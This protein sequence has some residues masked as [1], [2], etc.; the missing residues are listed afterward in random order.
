MCKSWSLHPFPFSC[1]FFPV[2]AQTLDARA[3]VP[4]KTTKC[5]RFFKSF[6]TSLPPTN[7][8]PVRRPPFVSP[9][10]CT[11]TPFVLLANKVPDTPGPPT[12]FQASSL[13]PREYLP[14]NKRISPRSCFVESSRASPPGWC[15]PSR[16]LTRG[17]SCIVPLMCG[18]ASSNALPSPSRR[19]GCH[20]ER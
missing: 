20:A 2:N 8:P 4:R 1:F 19:D 18:V 10:R 3:Q 13:F 5:L 15:D 16:A 14:Q 12:T 17:S 7:S 11:R 9:I 6:R